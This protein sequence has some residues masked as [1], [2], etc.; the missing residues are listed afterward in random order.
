M[1]NQVCCYTAKSVLEPP[2]T[3]KYGLGAYSWMF[4]VF[5]VNAS[6]NTKCFQGGFLV[7]GTTHIVLESAEDGPPTQGNRQSCSGCPH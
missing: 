1:L 7:R 4:Q 2:K 6:L 5:E 3:L